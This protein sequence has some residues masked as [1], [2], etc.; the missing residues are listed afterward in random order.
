MSMQAENK[1]LV[2]RWVKAMND[3]DLDALLRDVA[4]NLVNHGAIPEAQGADGLRRIVGK[5][6]EAMPDQRLTCEDVLA[7]GD[8]VVCRVTLEGTQ[9]GPL[10]FLRTPLPATGKAC[11]SEQIH[12]FRVAGGKIVEHWVGRD[13]IG[14]LRQLGH[15][16]FANG[17]AK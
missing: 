8:K 14:M 11:K 2:R 7:D 17:G 4:P 5:V 6:W 13:D 15:A 9:T 3:R 12:I 10:A 16:P 1:D